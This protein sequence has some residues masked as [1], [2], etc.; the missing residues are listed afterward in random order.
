M[1]YDF[2]DLSDKKER[3]RDDDIIKMCLF[4]SLVSQTFDFISSANNYVI[5]NDASEGND[6]SHSKK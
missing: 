2:K 5:E 3:T 1:L 4:F 6:K